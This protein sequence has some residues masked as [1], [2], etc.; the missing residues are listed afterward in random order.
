[1]GEIMLN[2]KMKDPDVILFKRSFNPL[3]MIEMDRFVHTLSGNTKEIIKRRSKE[4]SN[5]MKE[6]GMT[7]NR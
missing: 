7:I 6:G 1:M 5:T 4:S 2:L 3:H